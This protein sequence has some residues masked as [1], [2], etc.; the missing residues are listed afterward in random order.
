[1]TAF[2]ILNFL[3]WFLELCVPSY[4]LRLVRRFGAHQVGSFVVISFVSLAL[5]HLFNPPRAGGGSGLALSVVYA[6]ASV[7]LLI[8][9]GHVETVCQERRRIQFDEQELRTRLDSEARQKAED[10]VKI[11]QEMA[12]EIVRLQQ[13]LESL[14]VSERQYRLLFSQHPHPMWVFDLR[15]GRILTG[16]ES[17]LKLYGFSLHEFTA[18]AAKDLLCREAAK[19]FLADSAKPCSML[20]A[21]GIWQHRRKDRTPIEVEVMAF[22]LRFG[23][24]PARLIMAEDV[25]PR[26][27]RDF[28]L[29]EIQRMRVLRRVA[30]GVAHHFGHI[31]TVVE[32]QA[33]VLRDGREGSAEADHL[34]Q[35]L[36]ETRRGS[37]LIRQLL[38][39][40]ACEG[41]QPEPVDLN[42]FI[43]K[44]EAL[45]RRLVGERIS[46]EFHLGEALA[47]VQVD[48]RALDL[49]LVNLVL[50]ARE[51]LP[52]G[53]S[54]DIHTESAWVDS[55]QKTRQP[56][57]NVKPAHFVHLTVQDNGCGMTAEVQERLFEPFFTTRENDNA[58]G[59]GLATVYGAV[60]QHGGW[61]EFDSELQ[62]GTEFSV[63]LPAA[64]VV[65]QSKA[66]QE[67]A[68]ALPTRETIL[69]VEPHDRVRDLARHILQRNGYR[70][71]EADSP[72]TA[73][74]L[75]ETQ[76]KSVHLLLTDLTFPNG[77]SGRELADQLLQMN[78]Q[79]KVVYATAP[80][81]ADDSE[82]ELLQ[83]AKLLLKPYTPD[84]LVQ[85]IGSCFS[86]PNPQK[87]QIPA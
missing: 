19:A 1:M 46:L 55:H 22:D 43:Q 74:V 57:A 70:V 17:A 41:I 27:S 9:M 79:L 35:V 75:M 68:V 82:T 77:A 24:C 47:P 56:N 21:R 15:S 66:A 44:Q 87:V 71:I 86:S 67:S 53:G 31:L 81:S 8:G 61:V 39:A 5:L 4:A 11:K 78:T 36:S 84:R 20:E 59:L 6:A 63:F 62:R 16:N 60:K 25:A 29:S 2:G 45:L 50:N 76:A 49:I 73:S 10:L 69:L 65:T 23:D 12:Q 30:E 14:T 51:A 83:D 7:L 28:E 3:A 42:G 40:G 18:L 37:A 52:Q 32:G 72:S 85:T 38:A 13:Q 48:V 64:A 58:M 34:H 33:G 54:I 26:V 80:L